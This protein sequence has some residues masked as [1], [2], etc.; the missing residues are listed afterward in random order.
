MTD[1]LAARIRLRERYYAHCQECRRKHKYHMTY[2]EWLASELIAAEARI[3]AAAEIEPRGT[4]L[5]YSQIANL[6]EIG[7]SVG[8]NEC[9]EQFH[10]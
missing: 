4:Q 10:Q 3:E 6:T 5:T 8:W 2:E 9:R 1:T 7:K